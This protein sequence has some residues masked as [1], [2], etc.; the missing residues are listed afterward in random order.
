MTRLR[1]KIRA[2]RVT[3]ETGVLQMRIIRIIMRSNIHSIDAEMP[4][5][6]HKPNKLALPHRPPGDGETR[7]GGHEAGEAIGS[8]K[9]LGPNG[10]LKI[11]HNGETYS[12]RKTRFNKLILTK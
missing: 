6:L 7:G 5:I 9:L 10:E 11:R 1:E 4:K 8:D 3:S 2:L 12:L